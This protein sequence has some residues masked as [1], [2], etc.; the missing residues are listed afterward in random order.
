MK[1]RNKK[2]HEDV[3]DAVAEGRAF[4]PYGGEVYLARKSESDALQM[5]AKPYWEPE[6]QDA[7]ET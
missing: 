4:G 2:N 1:I 5:L 6:Q 3:W 7:R